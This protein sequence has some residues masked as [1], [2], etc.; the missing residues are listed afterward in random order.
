M[1]NDANFSAFC[2]KT[3]LWQLG[4]R[5]RIRIRKNFIASDNVTRYTIVNQVNLT[6]V[7][8]YM[9]QKETPKGGLFPLVGATYKFIY[10]PMIVRSRDSPEITTI[11]EDG[12]NQ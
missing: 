4:I 7:S 12:G 9:R 6:G 5:I 8:R 1:L 10:Q 11:R 2:L 3:F